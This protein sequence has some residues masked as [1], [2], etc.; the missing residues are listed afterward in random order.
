VAEAGTG[1]ERG[2]AALA[3]IGP[4]ILVPLLTR[5]K[6]RFLLYHTRQGLYWFALSILA[7]LMTLGVLFLLQKAKSGNVFLIFSVLLLLEVIGYCVISFALAYS[8][9]RGRMPM[10]PLLGDLAGER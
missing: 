4:L 7:F 8:A 1:S 3:Y 10:L 5:G 2:L 9:G 6:K